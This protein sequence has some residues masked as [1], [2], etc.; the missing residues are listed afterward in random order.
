MY[1]RPNPTRRRTLPVA[2]KRRPRRNVS[3]LGEF[4]WDGFTSFATGIYNTER[5]LDLAEQTTEQIQAAT[6][7]DLE[8]LKLQREI[9]Q[10]DAERAELDAQIRMARIEL[11]RQVATVAVPVIAVGAG[12]IWF[13]RSRRKKR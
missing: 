7:S 13:L 1:T 5:Q 3:G 12:A 11:F 8:Q 10:T 6:A 9:A 2:V 4:S